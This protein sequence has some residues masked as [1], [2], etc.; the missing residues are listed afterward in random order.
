LV[1]FCVLQLLKSI[2]EVA[3]LT[4]IIVALY[5]NNKRTQIKQVLL[6]NRGKYVSRIFTSIFI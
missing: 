4:P 5:Q 6:K 1:N 3:I 2:R